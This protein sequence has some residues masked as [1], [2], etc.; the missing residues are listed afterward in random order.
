MKIPDILSITPF[1]SDKPD[2]SVRTVLHED[3]Q[4]R[5]V[6]WQ[7]PKNGRLAPHQHPN[8]TDIWVVLQGQL[9]LL[10]DEEQKHRV[11][12]AGEAVVIAP[13]LRHGAVNQHD[14]DC[15]LLSIV[16]V[17]AGFQAA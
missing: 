12:K 3:E 11:A 6:L 16:P 8:G 15:I 9:V 1:L 4:M 5:L 17:Q 13:T 14:E 7:L 10:D 2:D